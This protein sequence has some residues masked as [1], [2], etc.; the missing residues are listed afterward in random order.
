MRFVLMLQIDVLGRSQ[1]CHRLDVSSGILL[2][3]FKTFLQNLEL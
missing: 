2:D 3:V 1:G